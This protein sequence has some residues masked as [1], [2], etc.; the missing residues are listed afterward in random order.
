MKI[1]KYVKKKRK[2]DEKTAWLNDVFIEWWQRKQFPWFIS[3]GAIPS[4]HLDQANSKT[5]GKQSHVGCNK[6]KQNASL[7]FG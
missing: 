6:L 5:V 7:N 1:I 3:C 4:Q 2:P